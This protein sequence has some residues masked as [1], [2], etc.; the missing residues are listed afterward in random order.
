MALWFF[1]SNG[2]QERSVRFIEEIFRPI[3]GFTVKNKEGVTVY[4]TNSELLEFEDVMSTGSK[5][6]VEIINMSFTC[7]LAPGDYF[8]SLGIA[9]KASEDVEPHDRRYDA[10]HIQVEPD[11]TMFGLSNMNLK[12]NKLS[13]DE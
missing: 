6:S 10:I 11:K 2:L 8:I 7:N 13:G 5:G 1:G 9:S 4:G 3:I 12:M